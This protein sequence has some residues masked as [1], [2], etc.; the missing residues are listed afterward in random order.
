MMPYLALR[1]SEPSKLGRKVRLLG[2]VED[3][4]DAQTRCVNVIIGLLP[5]DRLFCH[6]IIDVRHI[7]IFLRLANRFVARRGQS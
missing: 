4:T 5:N 1:T 6:E 3:P 7:L 2:L